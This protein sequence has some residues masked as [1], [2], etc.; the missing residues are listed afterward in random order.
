MATSS[1]I[2]LSATERPVFAVQN[3]GQSVAD[4]TSELLQENHE[5]H[6]IFFND[7]RFH[8]RYIAVMMQSQMIYCLTYMLE[9]HRTS[10][11]NALCVGASEKE[12][13]T[14][15]S[16]NADFQREAVPVKKEIVED[17]HDPAK[18]KK[19]LGNEDRYHDFLIFFQGEMNEKGW[20]QW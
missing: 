6:H 15:Y 17:M 8:V 10:P 2:K 18:F 7:K 13:Q 12:I 1:R 3:L 11:S 16:L 5:K 20:K 19:F 9:S 4:K 14:Q